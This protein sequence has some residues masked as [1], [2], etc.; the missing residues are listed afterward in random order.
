MNLYVYYKFIVSTD[1]KVAKR[2]GQMQ[3]LLAQEFSGLEYRLLKR[4]HADDAGRETWMEVY[5][6]EGSVD[7]IFQERLAQ[8]ALESNLPQPRLNELFIALK[9]A[10]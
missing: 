2:I 4:P 5:E 3:A 10:H 9:L 8:L 6:L 7:V 1:A